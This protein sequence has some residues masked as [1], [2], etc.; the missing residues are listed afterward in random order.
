MKIAIVGEFWGDDEAAKGLPFAGTKFHLLKGMLSHAGIDINDC[1]QTVV[2]QSRPARMDV[3]SY[4]GSKLDAIPDFRPIRPARYIRR[5]F[6]NEIDR[7]FAELDYVRPSLIISLGELPL[8]ALAKKT[9]LKKYRGTPI[10]AYGRPWKILPTYAPLSIIRNWSLRPIA[11]ADFTKARREAEFPDLRRPVRFVH[12]EP[13]LADIGE[14]Y[15]TYVKGVSDLSVDIETKGGQITEIGFAPSPERALVIPFY[16][17]AKPSGNYWPTLAE[18]RE[19][20]KWVRLILRHHKSFGQNFQYD[21]QYLWKTVGIPCPGFCD[22][23]MLLHHSLQPE[24]EKGLGFL[25]SLYTDEPNWKFM[26]ADH[27]TL[28]QADE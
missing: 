21:M 20:W 23:T 1:H 4:C 2:F 15:K 14:F 22:D 19:A 27:D 11:I 26:R 16:S 17:R 18:E 13:S 10:L 3:E 9:G 5:E 25:G 12:V 6:Q 24:M 7:L 28:K 8:W